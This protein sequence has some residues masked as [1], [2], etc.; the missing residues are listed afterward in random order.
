MLWT[1]SGFIGNPSIVKRICLSF[2]HLL[3][4]KNHHSLASL[5]R[6]RTASE[7]CKHNYQYLKTDKY[8]FLG[9]WW[10]YFN[11]HLSRFF[12]YPQLLSNLYQ[13]PLPTLNSWHLSKEI[14]SALKEN[15]K[16]LWEQNR[17]LRQH[18]GTDI[19]DSDSNG[20]TIPASHP[21]EWM[22][23]GQQK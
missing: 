23:L 14:V 9:S 11:V 2:A 1:E 7:L 8:Y 4:L 5:L 10:P 6:C 3:G 15:E 12:N 19:T 17:L 21:S 16:I 18:F 13:F 20:Y 22:S